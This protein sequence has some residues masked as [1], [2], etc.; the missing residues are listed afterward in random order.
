MDANH[1]FDQVEKE[2]F[3]TWLKRHPLLATRLGFV[4]ENSDR[5]PDGSL[6]HELDDHRVLQRTIL[7]VREFDPKK[8]SAERRINR[9][10]ALQLLELWLFERAELRMWERVPEAP[11]VVGNCI[12]QLLSRSTPPLNL[13]MRSIMK[14]LEGLPKYIDASRERLR[15]PVKLLVENELETLSR[16]PAFFNHVKEIGRDH[17]PP[18]PQRHLH[19]LLEAVQNALQRYEDWLIIDVLPDCGGEWWIG[20][21]LLKRVCENRGLDVAPSSL[22][23]TAEEE[24]ERLRERQRDIGRLIKR[25][26]MLEDQRDL[27]R[28]QHPDNFD[29]VLRYARECVSK[30]KQFAQRSKFVAMPDHDTLFVVETP[31]Y[32]RHLRPLATYLPAAKFEAKESKHESYYFV[33]PGDCDSDKMKEH[34]YAATSC[35]TIHHTYPGHHVFA[36]WA[37]QHPSLWRALSNAPETREGWAHYCEERV[38]EMGFDDQPQTRFITLNEQVFRASQA[39]LD[40]RLAAGK[41]TIQ[42][43]VEFLIDFVGMDRVAAEA[44]V[45]RILLAPGYALSPYY[46]RERL[47]ELKRHI[48]ERMKGRFSEAFFHT[49]IVQS[50]AIP[51][52]L[53]RTELEL[54]TDEELRRPSAAELEVREKEKKAEARKAAAAPKREPPKKAVARKPARK[55]PASRKPRKPV[56]KARPAKKKR[57]GKKR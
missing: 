34:N 30:L 37:S 1:R 28:Q 19:R 2:F 22:A 3:D 8:L 4:A 13:R 55:K 44:E 36:W 56:A 25:K 11:M 29:G 18:T 51:L 57:A 7:A 26:A 14:R 35:R 16:L 40:V 31:T 45:R 27:I 49:A 38:R 41:T 6:A 47:K 12:F 5:V 17:L 10:V 20:E 23:R 33:T 32:V 50:G 15:R 42:Q 53:L 21:D 39:V 24:I 9:E 46:G 52:S 54:K 48:K 43:A